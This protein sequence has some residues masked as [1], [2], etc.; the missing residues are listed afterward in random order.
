MTG[1]NPV[2]LEGRMLH[3]EP[4]YA[5]IRDIFIRYRC[6]PWVCMVGVPRRGD[7]D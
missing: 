1:M 2:D 7:L 4:L 3:Y 6:I 5:D